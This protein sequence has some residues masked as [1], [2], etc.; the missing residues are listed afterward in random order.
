MISRSLTLTYLCHSRCQEVGFF[1]YK[2]EMNRVNMKIKS[3]IIKAKEIIR[4]TKMMK[5]LYK[6][7]GI[8][9]IINSS[10]NGI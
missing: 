4:L 2:H 7:S 1:A 9:E 10:L 5:L 3:L 8:T 6:V